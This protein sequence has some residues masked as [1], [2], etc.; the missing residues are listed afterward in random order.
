[1]N[2]RIWKPSCNDGH[3]KN[4]GKAS[5]SFKSGILNPSVEHVEALIRLAVGISLV[6][7][8][9]GAWATYAFQTGEK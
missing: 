7:I 5:G 3:S 2:L 4:C 1:M 9:R 8:Q 6:F